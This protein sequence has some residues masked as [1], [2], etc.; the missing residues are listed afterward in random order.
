MG[1]NPPSD[2]DQRPTIFAGEA[3]AVL[4]AKFTGQVT[5]SAA[6]AFE[7]AMKAYRLPARAQPR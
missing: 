2:T 3:P 6:D 4:D 7:S 1:L 5:H